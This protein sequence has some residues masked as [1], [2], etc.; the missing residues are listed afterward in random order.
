MSSAGW[1][2]IDRSAIAVSTALL[3]AST[4]CS[5]Y[6]T[7]A[8]P[9]DAGRSEAGA[10]DSGARDASMS[11]DSGA[12]AAGGCPFALLPDAGSLYTVGADG[13]ENTGCDD[14]VESVCGAQSACCMSDPSSVPSEAGPQTGCYA[15]ALC[16]AID[17][18]A[19][20]FSQGSIDAAEALTSCA[21]P[22]G[23]C[24]F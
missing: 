19:G 18:C 8:V 23:D 17:D 22:C 21:V 3:A 6:H 9:P 10:H 7:V 24:P 16:S 13:G 1:L 14:C 11:G 2:V 15:F 12:D 5:N 4:A 20:G